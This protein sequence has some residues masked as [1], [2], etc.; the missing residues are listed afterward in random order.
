MKFQNGTDLRH[1]FVFIYMMMFTFVEYIKRNLGH[2]NLNKTTIVLNSV[3][4][5][6]VFLLNAT[7]QT[8]LGYLKRKQ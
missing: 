5:L 1:L 6:Y 2:F 8:N 7:I 4:P 3:W